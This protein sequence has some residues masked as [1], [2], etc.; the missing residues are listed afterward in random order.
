MPTFL[1]RWS[2]GLAASLCRVE[3]RMR[4]PKG[5]SG[6]SKEWVEDAFRQGPETPDAETRRCT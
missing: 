3:R 6:V 2:I 5:L 4:Y 1:A